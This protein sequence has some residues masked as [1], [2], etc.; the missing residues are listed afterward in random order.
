M[1][2]GSGPARAK[3]SID[4]DKIAGQADRA[5]A[6]VVLDLDAPQLKGVTTL[7]AKPP[8]AAINGIDIEAIKRSEI[9]VESKLSSEQ[10]AL[11]AGTAGPRPRHRGRRGR[12]AVRRFGQRCLG[13]A[14]PV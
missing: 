2:T 7:T 9:A 8:V 11:P 4:L 12:R 14:G 3:L 1:G 13:R 10:G 6:R 5:N